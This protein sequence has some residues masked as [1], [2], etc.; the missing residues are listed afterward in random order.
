MNQKRFVKIALVILVVVLVG[1]VGYFALSKP[2][3]K[4]LTNTQG[5]PLPGNTTQT[6][7]PPS[8]TN[9]PGWKT[10]NGTSFEI[11]YPEN[12]FIL[13]QVAKLQS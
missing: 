2:T 6:P 12:S 9:K 10:Y 11:Q 3:D 13:V 7:P 5:T 8:Q 4:Q 1:A